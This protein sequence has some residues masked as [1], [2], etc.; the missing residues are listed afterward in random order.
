MNKAGR[1][2]GSAEQLLTPQLQLSHFAFMRAVLEGIAP[3]AA[4]QRYLLLEIETRSAKTL[5][6]NLLARIA[7]THQDQ[8]TLVENALN[9]I[10]TEAINTPATT[11][12][13]LAEFASQFD[14]DM[15]SQADLLDLYRDELQV[16]AQTSVKPQVQAFSA[17]QAMAAL[18]A[19]QSELAQVPQK[20][21]LV[22]HW[23]NSAIC[24]SVKHLGILSLGNLCDLIQIRG[25]NWH[26]SCQRLGRV[27][28]ARLHQWLVDNRDSLDL[29]S[30][31][32]HVLKTSQDDKG[33]PVPSNA[34]MFP[35]RQQVSPT[36]QTAIVPLNYF[37]V[38]EGLEGRSGAFRAFEHS[39]TLAAQTDQQAISAWLNSVTTKSRHTYKAY[40]LDA[41]RLVLWSVLERKKAISS[42]DV[43]DAS[44]YREFLQNI[45]EHWIQRYQAGRHS[46]SWRPFKGQ[47]SEA[48]IARTLAAVAS[49]FD[50]FVKCGYLRIN[51]LANVRAGITSS[52]SV[53]VMRSF[54]DD[55]LKLMA[56]VLQK[57]PENPAKRRLRAVLMLLQ[58]TGLR[59]EEPALLTWGNIFKL[60]SAEHE[61]DAHGITV[62]GKGRKERQVPLRADVIEALEAHYQDRLAAIRQGQLSP[63]LVK[64]PKEQCPLV[65]TLC[66]KPGS[67]QGRGQG[68]HTTSRNGSVHDIGEI[69]GSGNAAL[70]A[71]GIHRLLKIFFTQID[72]SGQSKTQTRFTRCSAH[73]MRHTF[74]HR[75]MQSSDNNLPLVQQL[76]GHA[77]VATT[78]IYLK[79]DIGARFDAVQSMKLYL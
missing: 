16:E 9:S 55:D 68:G 29:H 25:S 52:R 4:A 39:N 47:L 64:L 59:I 41:E 31:L 10:A 60:R 65:S 44:A 12:K 20:A 61:Y 53:D 28:A 48:S 67:L 24:D 34:S 69:A 15:Y 42:L 5:F 19:I 23:F 62:I 36:L 8:A 70:S 58:A 79:T 49:M 40:R 17:T 46:A 26:K 77:S 32:L 30:E 76:L 57:A 66:A 18:R 51:G 75:V 43:N 6:K 7:K 73:W 71:A 22:R 74:A 33:H 38:P 11:Q 78:G 13:T 54:L 3:S 2:K 27:R 56:A 21:D 37:L 72:V 35:T 50:F 45:P 14:E 1:P 63:C